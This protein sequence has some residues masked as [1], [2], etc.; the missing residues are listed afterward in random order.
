MAIKEEIKPINWENEDDVMLCKKIDARLDETK[1]LHDLKR[2]HYQENA[3]YIDG[4]QSEKLTDKP[5]PVYNSLFPILRN[6][7]GLVT[8]VKPT[9]GVK[10][11]ETDEEMQA[12]EIEMMMQTADDLEKSL[13]EWWEDNNMQTTLQE[14][15]FSMQAFDDYFV[16]PY[17]DANLKDVLMHLVHPRHVRIDTAADCLYNAEYIAVDLYKSYKYCLDK[18]GEEKLENISFMAND[19]APTSEYDGGAI[20]DN[21]NDYKSYR[22][23]AHIVLFMEGE[24]MCY[25]SG[26]TILQKIRNPYWALPPEQQLAELKK[27]IEKKFK[28]EGVIGGAVQAVGD[29]VKGVV[30]METS[31]DQVEKEYSAAAEV[32]QPADN[33]FPNPRIPMI[34]FATYRMAGEQYSRSAVSQAIPTID[35]LNEEKQSIKHNLKRLAK[36]RVYIHGSMSEEQAAKVVES[37]KDVVRM[38]T[39]SELRMSDLMMVVQGSPLPGQIFQDLDDNKRA[40]DNLFGHHEVSRGGSDPNNPTKGGILALQ[41][42]DQTPVR[43]LTRNLEG[44]LQEMFRWVVQIRKV[45]KKQ[46]GIGEI[47]DRSTVDYTKIDKRYKV[48]VKSGSMMPVSREQQRI[49]AREEYSLGLIDPLTYHERVNTPD[50]EKTAKRVEMWQREKRILTSQDEEQEQMALQ[51]VELIKQNK[52]E[53]AVAMPEHNPTVFHDMLIMALKQNVFTSPEQEEH[54]AKLVEQYAQ[55]AGQPVDNQQPAPPAPQSVV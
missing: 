8:D 38:P 40:I 17:W 20:R 47:D 11:I 28:K 46:I 3:A 13:N 7:T 51:L 12:E 44:S 33:Y 41:E 16:M 18:W 53:E 52:F 6:M 14:I 35:A 48:F 24:W 32:Y 37:D 25:K 49:D 15:V 29:A 1:P 55:A 34:Q 26:N 23:L 10:I 2:K 22:N 27:G 36:P 4:K 45:Y 42:A 31:D 54:A 21:E 5:E 39:T 43:Y 9:P 19:E 30:G 50:P